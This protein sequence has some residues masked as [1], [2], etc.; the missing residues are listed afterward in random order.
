MNALSFGLIPHDC[1][2]TAMNCNRDYI[3]TGDAASRVSLCKRK[4]KTS[5]DGEVLDSLV[6]MPIGN[7]L[8]HSPNHLLTHS[9]NHLL[10]HSPNHLLTHSLQSP[11]EPTGCFL[12]ALYSYL[13]SGF[14]TKKSGKTR[15]KGKKKSSKK[16]HVHSKTHHGTHSLT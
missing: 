6:I 2:V 13:V 5:D 16:H 11:L 4:I 9:P 8:T 12:Y 15:K 3:I 10:T 7:V 14:H 1:S